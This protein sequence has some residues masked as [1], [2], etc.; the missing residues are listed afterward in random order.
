M[1][2][3]QSLALEPEISKS[4]GSC[5]ARRPAEE[6][7]DSSTR[8]EKTDG[9]GMSLQYVSKAHDVFTVV[10]YMESEVRW[11]KPCQEIPPKCFFS[12]CLYISAERYQGGDFSF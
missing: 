5:L 7:L 8:W 11:E 6:Q 3:Y 12:S 10:F 2:T 4:S 9:E 1:T